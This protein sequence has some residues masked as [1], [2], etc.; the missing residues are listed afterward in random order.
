VFAAFFTLAA[1]SPTRQASLRQAIVVHLILLLGAVWA[2]APHTPHQNVPLLGHV[3]L[4]A[5]IVE[6][7]MLLGWRLTQLPK[8]QALE[9]LLVSPMQPRHVFLGEALVGL[10]RLGL[11]TLSG[12]PVLVFLVADRILLPIDLL[13][14]LMVP[15]TWGAI[16]GLGLTAWAYAPQAVRRVGE[17][18]LMGLIVVYLI[19]GILA[20]EHLR[21]W[22]DHLPG[23]T[24]RWFLISFFTLHRNNPF[25][26]LHF[27]LSVDDELG[28]P[29]VRDMTLYAAAAVVTLLSICAFRLQGHFHELHY[30][31]IFDT[32]GRDR[33]T[34]GDWP[35]AW[36][37]VQRVTRYSGR[38]NLYLAG[39]FGI[40]YAVYLVAGP[41]WPT[42]L[43]RQIFDTVDRMGGVAGL[44][45]ALIVLSAVP[46]AFQYGLWDSSAQDRCRRLELLLLTN[47]SGRDY[48][49]A[50]A[51]AAWKRGRG[52]FAVAVLLLAAATI[53]G[54]ANVSQVLA[55]LAAGVVLWALYFALGFRAFSRGQQ[56]NRLG[57]LLTLGLPLATYALYQTGWAYVGALL[58]T[59]AVYQW[60]SQP[61]SAVWLLGILAAGLAALGIARHSRARCEAELR[62]WY[63]LHHGAKVL[64]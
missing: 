8:S 62:A 23:E 18:V 39:G 42:W 52:Y 11:V 45:T 26:L 17:R 20:G 53:S 47:L 51:T 54:Q 4:V 12:M 28:W 61:S 15:F 5:G 58:P 2:V 14:L 55:A 21:T 56:A 60:A 49:H 40:L 38:I 10:A 27:G 29:P 37:A 25:S 48:W 13:T 46:A 30:R 16:T 36:W 22:V 3:L 35:L 43:G 63:G 57:L 24:G 9:F 44:V 31:P 6:G 59:G 7:A 33:G 64:D 1:V 32:S 50:A 41:W 34:I 19:V